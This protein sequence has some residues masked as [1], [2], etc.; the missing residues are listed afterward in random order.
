MP[1]AFQKGSLLKNYMLLETY[2]A[3]MRLQLWFT[4]E[5][6]V[7]KMLIKKYAVCT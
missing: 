7:Q 3:K 1:R 4:L 2:A 6:N 5:N